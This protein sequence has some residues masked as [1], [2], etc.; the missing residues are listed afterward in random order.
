MHVY[1][2]YNASAP[3]RPEARAAWLDAQQTFKGNPNSTHYYGQQARALFDKS[4]NEL[5]NALGC[6]GHELV[7]CGSGTEANALAI[8]AAMVLRPGTQ[9]RCARIEH[10]SVLRNAQSHGNCLEIAVDADGLID[11][12]ALLDGLDADCG[13]ICLQYAN[14][15]LGVIQNI[16]ELI[17]A[18]RAHSPETLIHLDVC[19]GAGKVPVALRDWDVDFASIAGHKFGAPKGCGLLYSKLG[20]KVEPLIYGG[21]QQQDRRSG[22]EDVAAIASMSAAMQASLD[23]AQSE[24]QR[25]SALIDIAWQDIHIALPQAHFFARTCARLPNT[26]SLAYPGVKNSALIP[27]LDLAGFCVSPG[28][29]C[30]AARGEPSHVIAALGV[31]KTLAHSVVRVSIG[32]DTTEEQMRGFAQAYIQEIQSLSAAH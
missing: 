13:L 24:K 26:M 27:R 25:Q 9:I 22:T 21:R 11:Q 6:K 5:G 16:Q 12:T 31:D 15:E 32:S 20:H 30:M 3:L 14:N 7:L 4:R 8:H 29:A 1:L 23:N 17:P 19:Q 18:I 10:S 2:D 28:S